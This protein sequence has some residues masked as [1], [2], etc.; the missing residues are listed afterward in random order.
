MRLVWGKFN[1]VPR[2]EAWI[3]KLGDLSTSYSACGDRA[4]R[5]SLDLNTKYETICFMWLWNAVSHCDE[6]YI[7]Y[8][9]LKRVL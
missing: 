5:Q 8:K 1:A 7:D 2:C 4:L 3:S 9:C 6:K